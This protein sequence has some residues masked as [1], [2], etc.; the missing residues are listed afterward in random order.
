MWGDLKDIKEKF[1]EYF[2]TR[3]EGGIDFRCGPGWFILVELFLHFC[4]SLGLQFKIIQLKEKFGTL[5]IYAGFPENAQQKDVDLTHK[6]IKCIGGLSNET[7]E[8]CGDMMNHDGCIVECKSWGN[9]RKS[10]CQVCGPK[11][12]DGWRPWADDYKTIP[13][14]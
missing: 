14:S 4:K 12:K 6:L 11:Y 2:A 7:C 3:A 1:P 10:L 13:E 8:F 5:T 9:W